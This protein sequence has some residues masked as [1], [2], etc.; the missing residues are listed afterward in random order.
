MVQQQ[1]TRRTASLLQLS[2]NFRT[3]RT[4]RKSEVG[5]RCLGTPSEIPL[6]RLYHVGPMA[7]TKSDQV[8]AI[9]TS[10]SAIFER[11]D[12]QAFL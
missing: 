11:T 5:R 12:R 4:S 8:P 7:I 6:V 10:A 1:L 9:D 2:Q 3:Q